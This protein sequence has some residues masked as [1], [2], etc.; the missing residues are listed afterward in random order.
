MAENL[1][2]PIGHC[3]SETGRRFDFSNLLDN[4]CPFVDELDNLP[5]NAV[6]L[7]SAL[8]KLLLDRSLLG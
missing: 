7:L 1:L 3:N 8:C 2:F 4:C 5:V 6:D